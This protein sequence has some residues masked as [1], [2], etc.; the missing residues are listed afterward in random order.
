MKTVLITALLLTVAPGALP[1]EDTFRHPAIAAQE[2][3]PAGYDYASKFYPHPAWLHLLAE[4]PR[5]MGQHPAVL[6]FNRQQ[7]E[8]RKQQR[9]LKEMLAQELIARAAPVAP[10]S[11]LGK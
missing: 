3:K 7:R 1:A 2:A 6:V 5:Q 9:E 4:A 11:N 8:Q 10:D